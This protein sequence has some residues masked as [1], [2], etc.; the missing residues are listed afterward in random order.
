MKKK[1]FIY[2]FVITMA[3]FSFFS[4][5]DE[6]DDGN[7]EKPNYV[8][9]VAEK[10]KTITSKA[11]GEEKMIVIT[12]TKNGSTV[13][14]SVKSHPEWLKATE[15]LTG[16]TIKF[17]ENT[18]KEQFTGEIVLEQAETGT[19]LALKA[20]LESV[21]ASLNIEESYSTARLKVLSIK[22]EVSGYD[23]A[24]EYKWVQKVDGGTDIILSTEKD[25]NFIKFEYFSEIGKNSESSIN[26]YL[27]WK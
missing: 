17:D 18:L 23:N 3:A 14:Y 5:E 22:P 7:T 2:L 12:S 25:L 8:F 16:L 9:S 10:D 19:L 1:S 20:V 27:R 11:I 15:S 13:G 4:C 21:E 26:D 24:P 6:K